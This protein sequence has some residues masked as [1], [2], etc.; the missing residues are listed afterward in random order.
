MSN[1]NDLRFKVASDLNNDPQ[2]FEINIRKHLSPQVIKDYSFYRFFFDIPSDPDGDP[3]HFHVQIATDSGFTNIVEQRESRF[4]TSP[5]FFWDGQSYVR[6]SSGGVAS[7][8]YGN[9]AY[10]IAFTNLVREN[11]YYIRVRA[12][13]GISYSSWSSIY[14][15]I[16]PS[17]KFLYQPL[18]QESFIEVP[19][20]GVPFEHYGAYFYYN[21]VLG[22]GEYSIK[23][24]QWDGFEFGNWF[25][26]SLL[27]GRAAVG[28]E[29]V[30]APSLYGTYAILLVTH[31]AKPI[32][33]SDNR[34][35]IDNISYKKMGEIQRLRA[36]FSRAGNLNPA[37]VQLVGRKIVR[38]P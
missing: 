36:R 38:Q 26:T 35:S 11:T 8:Y 25:E 2:G 15:E 30:Y 6:M 33:I 3:L 24:R 34:L 21:G 19:T 23:I 5:W 28:I 22:D 14:T 1:L 32:L 27:V 37:Q 10:Y 29:K 20:F 31:E 12:W 13:D 17:T 9:P 4:G 7:A 16:I 18:G